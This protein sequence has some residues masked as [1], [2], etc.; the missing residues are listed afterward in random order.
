MG[1]SGLESLIYIISI[2]HLLEFVGCVIGER[3]MNGG[4]QGR[5]G[6]WV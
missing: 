2:Y 6:C 4:D 5:Y 3:L 1:A